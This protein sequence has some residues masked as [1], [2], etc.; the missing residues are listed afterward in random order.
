MS[1]IALNDIGLRPSLLR[2]AQK[3]AR[4]Q[5]KTPP[6]YVRSLIERDLLA[7]KSFDEILKPVRQRVKKRGLTAGELDAVVTQARKDISRGS[8]RKPRRWAPVDRRSCLTAMFFFKL[9]RTKAD[10]RRSAFACST[11]GAS[12]F[13]LRAVLDYPSVRASLR[14]LSDARIIAFLERLTYKSTLVR[15]VPHALDYPRARQD[16]PYID[17]A[18][19]AKADYLISRDKDLLSLMTGHSLVCKHFRQLTRPLKV[20]DPVRFLEI[21][22][23]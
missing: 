13:S 14:G 1:S 9:W 10:R 21:L 19:A 23:Q 20:L 4:Q 3:K 18:V 11:L 7:S 6:E 8:K 12:V 5:G 17:L 15:R 16:E 2:A 22:A